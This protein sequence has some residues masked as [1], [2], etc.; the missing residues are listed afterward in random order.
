MLKYTLTYSF[1]VKPEFIYK[2]N[3]SLF[4]KAKAVLKDTSVSRSDTEMT[5]N[6]KEKSQPWDKLYTRPTLCVCVQHFIPLPLLLNIV[7]DVFV[8]RFM[9]LTKID[10]FVNQSLDIPCTETML[11]LTLE[12]H[13]HTRE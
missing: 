9:L 1:Q 2:S 5:S 3:T 8:Y 12:T 13:V 4:P 7:N 11:L 10:F 6:K